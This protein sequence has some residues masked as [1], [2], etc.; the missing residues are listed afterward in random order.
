LKIINRILLKGID[1][2]KVLYAD[3]YWLHENFMDKDIYYKKRCL[4]RWYIDFIYSDFNIDTTKD[5]H[6]LCFRSLVRDDYKVLFHSITANINENKLLIEDYKIKNE[7]LNIEASRFLSTNQW[8]LK[9]IKAD[10]PITKVCLYIKFCSYL[11]VLEK[12]KN[13]NFKRLVLFADMQPVENLLAQYFRMQN[14]ETVTLQHGL[15]VEYKDMDTINV[16]NYKHCVSEF[17]LAW[18][19]NTKLLIEKY[20]PDTKAIICGKPKILMANNNHNVE[21]KNSFCLIVLD[22]NIFDKQ[23]FEMIQCVK[24]SNIEL[25]IYVKFHPSNNKKA[26]YERFDWIKEGGELINS[27]LVVGHTTTVIYEALALRLNVLKYTTEIP[28][29]HLP[30]E[31][32]FKTVSDFNAKRN[33]NISLD[34][35]SSQYI[36]CIDEKS[37]EIYSLFFNKPMLK[38]KMKKA[39]I[40]GVS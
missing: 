13:I 26:Y 16:I 40:T 17:F 30:C 19:N 32:E 10:C 3:L 6:T 12:I 1:I 29:L 34:E 15:Y 14:I 5:I 38:E 36:N 33:I 18:G 25:D 35:I 9:L 21:V 27:E 28:S 7:R 2:N 23:N 4:K 22:Q 31:L 24:E 20:C 37:M 11:F 8:V 39:L